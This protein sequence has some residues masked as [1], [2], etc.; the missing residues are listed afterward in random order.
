MVKIYKLRETNV[1]FEYT[2]ILR[3]LRNAP[4]MLRNAHL[5]IL[6]FYGL[7]KNEKVFLFKGRLWGNI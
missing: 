2:Q 5:T 3:M 7:A 4:M 6:I 1:E